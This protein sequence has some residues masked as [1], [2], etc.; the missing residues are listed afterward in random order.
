MR[1]SRKGLHFKYRNAFCKDLFFFIAYYGYNLKGH[2]KN[3]GPKL[4]FNQCKEAL[5]D[6]WHGNNQFFT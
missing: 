5:I 4:F 3:R 2:W 6:W 1:I